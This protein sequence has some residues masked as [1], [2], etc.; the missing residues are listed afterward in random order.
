MEGSL[1]ERKRKAELANKGRQHT[2]N[3]REGRKRRSA[4]EIFSSLG[5]A[6]RNEGGGENKLTSIKKFSLNLNKKKK[7]GRG[8]KERGKTRSSLRSNKQV[9]EREEQ[10][11]RDSRGPDAIKGKLFLPR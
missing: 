4:C 10:R 9:E 5:R 3:R 11:I 6:G 7:G 2:H 8:R 1:P